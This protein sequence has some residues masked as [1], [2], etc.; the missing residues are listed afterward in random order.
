MASGKDSNIVSSD[1]EILCPVDK[2][3]RKR[4][5]IL[6]SESEDEDSDLEVKT[7]RTV[8]PLKCESED[9]MLDNYRNESKPFGSDTKFLAPNTEDDGLAM[10]DFSDGEQAEK[11][12]ICLNKFHG[13]DIATPETCDHMFCLDCLQEWAKNVNTCPIDRLKFNLILIRHHK[14]EKI[15]RR[16]Y[17][18]NPELPW[19]TEFES[20][21]PQTLIT[22]CE[23]CGEYDSEETLLLCHECQKCYHTECIFP[24]LHSSSMDCWLCPTCANYVRVR[25]KFLHDVHRMLQGIKRFRD[26]RSFSSGRSSHTSSSPALRASA[27]HSS[28]RELVRLRQRILHQ[29]SYFRRVLSSSESSDEETERTTRSTSR[30][31]H[32][33]VISNGIPK[34]RCPLMGKRRSEIY[35]TRNAALV[36]SAASAAS[37]SRA[38]YSYDSD[39]GVNE[40]GYENAGNTFEHPRNASR[41]LSS[42]KKLNSP[43][44]SGSANSRL[45][46]PCPQNFDIVGSIL[47]SQTLLHRSDVLTLK[48][49]GTLLLSPT[50]DS[51]QHAHSASTSSP[52]PSHNSTKVGQNQNPF[53][54]SSVFKDNTISPY[55]SDTVGQQR[56]LNPTQNTTSK[57]GEMPRQSYTCSSSTSSIERSTTYDI[58]TISRSSIGNS[59]NDRYGNDSCSSSMHRSFCSS[60]TSDDMKKDLRS[61]NIKDA[62]KGHHSEDEVDIYSDIESV[63]EEEGAIID[64]VE[65]LKISFKCDDSQLSNPNEGSDSSDNELV[66]DEDMPVDEDGEKVKEHCVNAN[67]IDKT[68]SG[69]R[70]EAVAESEESNMSSIAQSDNDMHM[71]DNEVQSPSCSESQHMNENSQPG[72]E[73]TGDTFQNDSS[74]QETEKT[75]ENENQENNESDSDL[76]N[77]DS[78]NENLQNNESESELENENHKNDE[79]ESD[80]ENENT[81]NDESDIEIENAKNDES[82]LENENGKN[83]ESDVENENTKNDESDLENENTKN[84]G[85]DL[86]NENTKNDESDLENNKNDESDLENNKND[87]SDLENE[88]TKND[89]SDLENENTKNEESESGDGQESDMD[90]QMIEENSL[91]CAKKSLEVEINTSSTKSSPKTFSEELKNEVSVMQ[92]DDN[93][94]SSENQECDSVCSENVET[95]KETTI[96]TNQIN[97]NSNGSTSH[98][99]D[100]ENYHNETNSNLSFGSEPQ[101]VNAS[102][103]EDFTESN[104]DASQESIPDASERADVDMCND[105]SMKSDDHDDEEN[106]DSLENASTPCLDENL[107]DQIENSP[108][109]NENDQE[110]KSALAQN[111]ESEYGNEVPVSDLINVDVTENEKSKSEPV[112]NIEE[113]AVDL[114]IEDISE[115]GS[116]DLDDDFADETVSAADPKKTDFNDVEREVAKLF[117]EGNDTFEEGRNSNASSRHLSG[118]YSRYPPSHHSSQSFDD[119]EEGEIIEDKPVRRNRKRCSKAE[120]FHD[121]S[122]DYSE[123]APR[124]N[125]SDLPRIP[126]IKRDREK[127]SVPEDI[128]LEVKR[129]SVL[130]RVD[131]GGA[132]ISWKRLSKHTRE[133]SYRDGRPKDERLLYRERESR[134]KDKKNS[135]DNE[136]R[137]ESKSRDGER[138]RDDTKK[139]DI[140]KSKGDYE[141]RSRKSEKTKE[142]KLV[143][144]NYPER[145]KRKSHKEKHSKEKHSKDKKDKDKYEKNKYSKDDDKYEKVKE[146]VR[147]EREMRYDKED[148]FERI[149]YEKGKFKEKERKSKHKE[150]KT[151]GKSSKDHS[152]E[153]HKYIHVS[154]HFS[155]KQREREVRKIDDKLKIVVEQKESRKDK[156][157][158]HKDRKESKHEKKQAHHHEHR[159]K[160]IERS[161]YTELASIESKEIFAKGDSIII[162]VNFNR[163]SSPKEIVSDNHDSKDRKFASEDFESEHMSADEVKTKSKHLSEKVKGSHD[164]VLS[165]RPVTPPEKTTQ[166]MS[167]SECYWQGGDDPDG[168]NTP[169]SEKSAVDDACN[170]EENDTM[171]SVDAYEGDN[172]SNSCNSPAI[173]EVPSVSKCDSEVEALS[174]CPSDK[175]VESMLAKENENFTSKRRS[176]RSPSPPSPADNDSYDPC[177]P[178]RSPSPPPMPPAPPLPTTNPK[179]PPSPELPPLPPE[180]EPTDV[181]RE[182][183][184]THKQSVSS[185]FT[186][187]S[188]AVSSASQPVTVHTQTSVAN[189]LSM[190]SILLP[191]PSFMSHATSTANNLQAMSPLIPPRNF[192][193]Q[194]STHPTV[195]FPNQIQ[196]VIRGNFVPAQIHTGSSIPPPPNPPNLPHMGSVP[197][198]PPPPTAMTLL[199][200]VRHTQLNVR[201][202]LPPN[203]LLQNLT[204]GHTVSIP[205]MQLAHMHLP[206]NMSGTITNHHSPMMVPSQSQ[207]VSLPVTVQNQQGARPVLTPN[208]LQ[209]HTSLMQNQTS[210]SA[211]TQGNLVNTHP[212][213]SQASVNASQKFEKQSK[214]SPPGEKTEVID[215]EVDSPYSPGDSPSMDSVCDY[216][217]TSS[218][219]PSSPK[220]KDVFDSL[221]TADQRTSDKRTHEGASKAE[222]L[223]IRSDSKHTSENSAKR[224]KHDKGDSKLR[225]SVRM[226]VT[227][228]NKNSSR[229]EQKLS[230]KKELT[231]LDDS[232]LKILDELPSSAVEM[233]VKEKFLKKLNRQERVV[234]EV[235]L[236]LKPYYKSRE[237][238]KEEYKDILRKSV[239]KI[240]H[241]K[242]G[243]INPV[244]VKYLVECYIKKIKHSR[245]KADKKK[246]KFS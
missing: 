74:F 55:K 131:L 84:D 213:N 24:P 101:N 194:V 87:E 78:K 215:M 236:S 227:D 42:V 159:K 178:T 63:C 62:G 160:E 130:G 57:Y 106:L 153:K 47:Q 40:Y 113:S 148:R 126:K 44:Q 199:S 41:Q 46:E 206:P 90:V 177:E 161:P 112:E 100:N 145:E 26:L 43:E 216:S 209:N 134:N 53:H 60:A 180:P 121:D 136:R 212:P 217:P 224:H 8:K 104:M 228:K 128:P 143:E 167:V 181:I 89:E 135:N 16:I 82:D 65:P 83:D 97:Q 173:P 18:N 111:L 158:K 124:V 35:R 157:N 13:Q 51:N 144:W 154:D 54:N 37:D 95:A 138:R 234:E 237:I 68:H 20:E 107:D 76:E 1:D 86:E 117:S 102:D 31:Y 12:A 139:Q 10:N 85:S 123:L 115:A 233:Q 220:S 165:K 58:N 246:S 38:M 196:Q 219:V 91:D 171:G 235:K 188:S 119:Q 238:S 163:A 141:P 197:P 79:S 27:Q 201:P 231:K 28:N 75:V 133:R 67:F 4:K 142:I 214:H 96:I 69:D 114:G 39:D 175:M 208:Q 3:K 172:F 202:A 244:K 49:D 223:K 109:Q 229:K 14:E 192:N 127:D 66:I 98:M 48:R 103:P 140:D 99:V 230:E 203:S 137:N 34:A 211:K 2:H 11:C 30:L 242:S 210:N 33:Q 45:S 207:T 190:P 129:T 186:A 9:E 105:T 164:S 50:S 243:E 239:P 151:E 147:Y 15:I 146:E 64:R 56:P 5:V 156:S 22:Y 168:N 118:D 72:D 149:V 187:V 19:F 122:E 232:Q 218:P 166:V 108:I 73:S 81:K 23:I 222:K 52:S 36:S 116:E 174:E 152:R 120:R 80:L 169:T 21:S 71:T 184:R 225:H 221:L 204:L 25:D 125:I 7:K 6:S 179:P 17:I 195:I 198:P 170:E 61:S 240:C 191:P 200:Q 182:D 155:D 110:F 185:E 183:P 205:Q 92:C 193:F 245:K 70:N 150:R 176:P 88:N 94:V 93:S 132:D 29:K 241:N 226:Q 162:N 77:E 32:N 189:P 59:S